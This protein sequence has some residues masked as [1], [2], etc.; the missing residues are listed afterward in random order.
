MTRVWALVVLVLCVAAPAWA[1]PFYP[2]EVTYPKAQ[3]TPPTGL[4]SNNRLF[5]AATS[6]L[7]RVPVAV[8]GG[9]FPYTVTFVGDAEWATLVQDEDTTEWSVEGTPTNATTD[10]VTLTI[11]VA[12]SCGS[13]PQTVTWAI[14]VVDDGTASPFRWIDGTNGLPTCNGR[15]R[16][17]QGGSTTDCPYQIM[18]QARSMAT[19]DKFLVFYTTGTYTCATCPRSGS[20]TIN[21]NVQWNDVSNPTVWICRAGQTITIDQEYMQDGVN[22]YFFQFNSPVWIDHCN[23]TRGRLHAL[24]MAVT[25]NEPHILWNNTFST[26]GP[27]DAAESNASVIF[28]Q[29]VDNT[30]RV[31]SAVIGV[32]LNDF[33]GMPG[34]KSYSN[35]DFLIAA[36]SYSGGVTGG[37]DGV[38][39]I[40]GDHERFT[41]R[42]SSGTN[43]GPLL[44]GDWNAANDA[45]VVF[46]NFAN[47]SDSGNTVRY[48]HAGASIS[49]S[50]VYTA[51]NTIRGRV[52]VAACSDD[53]PF[54]FEQNVI[55]NDAGGNEVPYITY[56]DCTDETRITMTNNLTGDFGDD[57]IDAEGLLVEPFFTSDGPDSMTPK[58]HMRMGDGPGPP[59]V[60]NA[61]PVNFRQLLRGL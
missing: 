48:N 34:V 5:W 24:R 55:I 54:V 10:D 16:T 31:G 19:A 45:E 60:D 39:A 59:P 2:L 12:D 11:Q 40:K 57:I 42:G 18:E 3:G 32:T 14:N 58:G 6:F 23:F 47:A 1:Q 30:F 52:L 25:A 41:I 53:G 51:R 33:D 49:T 20:G 8:I 44:G 29:G 9:C 50:N 56:I 35:A 27:P 22:T 43:S 4:T 21:A 61:D 26:Y 38:I 13:T 15:F 28:F 46:N 37:I 17:S 36:L 7:Y